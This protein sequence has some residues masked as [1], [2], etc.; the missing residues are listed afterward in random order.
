MARPTTIEFPGAVYHV[1]SRGDKDE[2][3]SEDNRERKVFLAIL[4]SVVGRH[5]WF[6]HAYSFIDNHYHFLT[7]HFL[8]E[9]ADGNLSLGMRRPNG[10]YTQQFSKIHHTAGRLFQGRFKAILVEMEGISSIYVDT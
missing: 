4:E 6:C 10:V 2:R 3:I 7:D 1:T 5:N 9:T 8:T